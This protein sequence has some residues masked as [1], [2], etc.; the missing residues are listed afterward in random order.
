MIQLYVFVTLS[1]NQSWVNLLF[2]VLRDSILDSLFWILDSRFSI[3]EGIQ[4]RESS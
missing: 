1:R 2:S 4:N 3:S